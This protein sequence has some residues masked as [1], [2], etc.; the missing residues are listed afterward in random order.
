ME[1]V[2]RVRNHEHYLFL[3]NHNEEQKEVIVPEESTDLLTGTIYHKEESLTL[4][5]KGVVILKWFEE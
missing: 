1:A 5:A 4:A 3:L 2:E